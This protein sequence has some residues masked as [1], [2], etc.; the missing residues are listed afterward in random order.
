MPY[1]KKIKFRGEAGCKFSR[2]EFYDLR[3]EGQ[4]LDTSQNGKL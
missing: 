1:D 4:K 2:N 3:S